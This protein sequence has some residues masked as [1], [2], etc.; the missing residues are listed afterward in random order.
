MAPNRPILNPTYRQL[1]RNSIRLNFHITASMSTTATCAHKHSYPNC[2]VIKNL[3][4]LQGK[5]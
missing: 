1:L 3:D 5:H 2:F 4:A